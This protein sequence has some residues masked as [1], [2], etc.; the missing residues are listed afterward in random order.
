MVDLHIP[1]NSKCYW[2]LNQAESGYRR[3]HSIKAN[4][5]T[6]GETTSDSS[7]FSLPNCPVW[8]LYISQDHCFIVSGKFLRCTKTDI[9]GSF[10]LSW[11]FS[12][13]WAIF[14]HVTRVFLVHDDIC[15]CILFL[16]LISSPIVH[17]SSYSDA[18]DSVRISS[19]AWRFATCLPYHFLYSI[20]NIQWTIHITSSIFNFL[21][22]RS[23]RRNYSR[24][25]SVNSS[26]VFEFST[27]MWGPRQEL[28]K[29]NW[30]TSLIMILNII[31]YIR[32]KY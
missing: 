31:F 2:W 19:Q 3:K 17:F 32:N 5:W 27:S 16:N 1:V 4:S 25:L 6:L 18:I 12:F 11:L 8:S 10:G 14:S 13:I 9:S 29:K 30:M 7:S 21:V 22:A 20:Y 24:T 26:K 28:L 15:T 23:N